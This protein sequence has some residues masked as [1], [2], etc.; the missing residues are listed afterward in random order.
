M[1]STKGVLFHLLDV[2]SEIKGMGLRCAEDPGLLE[3]FAQTRHAGPPAALDLKKQKCTES[4][5]LT[6]PSNTLRITYVRN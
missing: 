2:E 3:G 6:A 1:V 4:V 5:F